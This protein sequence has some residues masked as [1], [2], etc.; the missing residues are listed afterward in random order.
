MCENLIQLSFLATR[1]VKFYLKKCIFAK[2]GYSKI[3]LEKAC[4][5]FLKLS[6]FKAKDMFPFH[7]KKVLFCLRF[8]SSK[9]SFVGKVMSCSHNSDPI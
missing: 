9:F 5:Y 1:G 3:H 6:L 4:V 8:F 2:F 7:S